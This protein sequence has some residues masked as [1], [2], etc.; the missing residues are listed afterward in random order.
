MRL[1]RF[2]WWAR[3]TKT[4]GAA[5]Q[6]AEGG[7][8]RLDGRR[9]DRAHALVRIGSVIGFF[10][11]GRVRIVRVEA[12]PRRRGPASEAAMLVTELANDSQQGATELTPAKAG[13]SESGE[14]PREHLP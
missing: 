5:Q 13:H 2:L 10:R 8:L 14:D 12:L 6:L 1:D 9:I 11:G 7:H 3:I 4:R